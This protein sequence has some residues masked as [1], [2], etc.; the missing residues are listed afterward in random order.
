METYKVRIT[1]AA[2]KDMEEIYRYIAET[3][4]AP[5]TA[6]DQYDRIAEA[7]LSLAL[8]PERNRLVDFEPERAAGLR[9]QLVDNYSVF[10]VVRGGQVIVTHVLYSAS[11]IE[12]RLR[13]RQ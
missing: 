2:L 13:E 5:D 3:L 12:A 6:A 11:D 8:F 10:Y 7:A 4:H 1:D 9:R